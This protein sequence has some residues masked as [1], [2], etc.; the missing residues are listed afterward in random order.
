VKKQLQKTV[1]FVFYQTEKCG[2][3][4]STP[5]GKWGKTIDTLQAA[6]FISKDFTLDKLSNYLVP[7]D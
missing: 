2:V 4:D 6:G 7:V 1:E 3:M 5:N